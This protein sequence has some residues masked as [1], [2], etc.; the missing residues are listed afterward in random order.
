MRKHYHRLKI[1]YL[2]ELGYVTRLVGKWHLGYY[3][4]DFT[5]LNRGFD[6]HFGY[7]NGW[8]RYNDSILTVDDVWGYDARDNYNHA[9]DRFRGRYATDVFT[10]E[11]VNIIK[12]HDTSEPLFL[13]LSHLAVHAIVGDI[14]LVKNQT[15]ND[16]KFSY[17][18]DPHRRLFAGILT[19]LD[20]SV[21]KVIA[22]LNE[23]KMLENSIILFMSDNGGATEDN[24]ERASFKNSASN[25]PLRGWKSSVTE[26]GVR[27]VATIWSPLIN[28]TSHSVSNEIIHITDWLPTFYAAAGGNVEKL[29]E[30]D[31]VNQWPY[32]TGERNSSARK[33]VL[34]NINEVTND[35]AIII[36]D[37]K[38]IRL[39]ESTPKRYEG[40]R[41][42]DNSHPYNME[43]VLQSKTHTV[44]NKFSSNTF[45][46]VKQ[47]ASLRLRSTIDDKCWERIEVVEKTE[48]SANLR[49]F[50]TGC[51]FNIKNDPCEFTDLSE[52]EPNLI[53]KFQS[54]MHLYRRQLVP[55][56]KASADPDCDP[57][58]YHDYWS[59]WVESDGS[60][61]SS[62]SNVV[63][64]FV[65]GL[66]LFLFNHV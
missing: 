59:P 27:G 6:S 53:S 63:M 61:G 16:E 64:I 22:A 34:I 57:R 15:E 37:W 51:L 39:N 13:D 26:G 50:Q 56:Q 40:A 1:Y 28:A 25:W 66:V 52:N 31:G 3:Q 29:G 8:T 33:E 18:K 30:I 5:P 58:K 60:V 20:K 43:Q 42:R 2:K 54:K 14:L 32:L 65:A 4:N 49:C 9:G 41:G 23:K 36:D 12:K 35:S 11:A 21:G 44:L 10:E 46:S 62:S 45:D 19:E 17:I 55:Q 38:Y 7:Y 24:N 47:F 48:Y